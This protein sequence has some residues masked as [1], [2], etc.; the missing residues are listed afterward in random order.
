[1]YKKGDSFNYGELVWKVGRLVIEDYFLVFECGY[2]VK[3]INS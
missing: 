1:M 3:V 2:C